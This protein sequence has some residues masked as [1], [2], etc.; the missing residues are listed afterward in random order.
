MRRKLILGLASWFGLGFL[1]KAPGTWGTLGALPLWWAMADL[2]WAQYLTVTLTFIS[3]SI[4]VSHE[5]EMIFGEHDVSHIVIDEV[6][7]L[8]VAAFLVPF[9]WPEVM[10]TFL[11]FRLFD[12]T[13][14]WPIRWLDRH[15]GGGVGV[16]VDDVVAGA[17]ACLVMHLGFALVGG[18]S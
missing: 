15:I 9:A 14:P 4:W 18:S 1:P 16:V 10:A 3:V 8:L 7:G 13:K 2:T 11:L 5:A 6:A 12:I 17:A